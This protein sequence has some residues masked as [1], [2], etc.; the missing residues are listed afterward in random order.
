MITYVRRIVQVTLLTMVLVFGA[1]LIVG[2]LDTPGWS[3]P[4]HGYSTKGKIHVQIVP[5]VYAGAE[6]EHEAYVNG[7]H[8]SQSH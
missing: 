7:G 4:H 6:V 3:D 8:G 1:M 2:S 5:W